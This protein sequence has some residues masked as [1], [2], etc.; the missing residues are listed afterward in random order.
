MHITSE[1]LGVSDA[2][3][4]PTAQNE[5]LNKYT[6]YC[7]FS[8]TSHPVLLNARRPLVLNETPVSWDTGE[9]L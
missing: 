2:T 6:K 5:D 4:D 7:V 8:P 3:K 9:G 1:I